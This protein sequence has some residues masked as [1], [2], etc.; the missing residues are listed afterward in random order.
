MKRDTLN[1]DPITGTIPPSVIKIGFGGTAECD[2]SPVTS[3]E[4]YEC[5]RLLGQGGMGAVYKARDKRLNRV[6]DLKFIRGGDPS[7]L[8]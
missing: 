1:P 3:R 7:L 6:V 5:L 4:R 2:E 8:G